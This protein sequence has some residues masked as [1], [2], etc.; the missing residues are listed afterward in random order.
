V[1]AEG[2]CVIGEIRWMK[3]GWEVDGWVVVVGCN[4]AESLPDDV[5]A[6]PRPKMKATEWIL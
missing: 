5:S 2:T 4:S 1:R 6:S 3:W